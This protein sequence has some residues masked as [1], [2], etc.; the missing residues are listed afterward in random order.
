[1]NGTEILGIIAVLLGL[2]G[3]L[4]YYVAILRGKTRPHL[5]TRLVWAVV[6]S[7]I[8]LGQYTAGGVLVL[9]LQVCQR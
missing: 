3:S 5:Y 4:I 6:E 2:T 1:M 8:F 7:I 9:G